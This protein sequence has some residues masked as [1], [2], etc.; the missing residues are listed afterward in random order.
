MSRK[1]SHPTRETLPD[2]K[3]GNVV[4]ARFVNMIMRHGKKAVAESILYGAIDEIR[5]KNADAIALIEKAL[6]NVA[7]LLKSS[8]A[9]WAVQPTRCRLKCVPRAAPRWRCAG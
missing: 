1:G 4:I 3:F 2:P 5:N 9:E 8:P 7:R 6:G